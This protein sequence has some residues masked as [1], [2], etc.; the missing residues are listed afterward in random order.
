VDAGVDDLV[1]AAVGN[2]PDDL[3]P[4]S[5]DGCEIILMMYL[6][7]RKELNRLMS[8]S[9]LAFINGG[10]LQ[11]NLG[12]RRTWPWYVQR[13]RV[14]SW[15]PSVESKSVNTMCLTSIRF[16]AGVN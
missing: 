8:A 1:A 3:H 7:I 15:P 14:M 12:M 11:R 5:V 2:F 6:L 4:E 9:D 10:R 16:S 13:N